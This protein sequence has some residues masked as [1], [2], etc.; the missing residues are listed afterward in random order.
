MTR[1]KFEADP[2]R[3]S[4]N[5][6]R[7]RDWQHWPGRIT[8]QKT[9]R[10][11]PLQFRQ[12]VKEGELKEYL[13]PDKSRRYDPEELE[14]MAA[15]MNLEAPEADEMTVGGKPI[16]G[17]RAATDLLKQAQGHNERLLDVAIR[18]FDTALK[19]M[20]T[21]IDRLAAE[22]QMYAENY[23]QG[24]AAI[25]SAK[26]QEVELATEAASRISAEERRTEL[27][28]ALVPHIGPI[29]GR[30]SEVAANALPSVSDRGSSSVGCSL[31][32]KA[33]D[34]LKRIGPDKLQLAASLIHEEDQPLANEVI[35]HLKGS[36]N[37]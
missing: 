1:P 3:I 31:E 20:S 10:L 18:G 9:L 17:M 25:T 8:A 36:D 26:N 33:L 35:E 14:E 30:L 32:Q 15:S 37:A 5:D 7:R 2:I 24:L 27:V 11:T 4:E 12:M 19:A 6:E 29:L 34:L 13:A 28:R 21:T 16:E 23:Y 22:N